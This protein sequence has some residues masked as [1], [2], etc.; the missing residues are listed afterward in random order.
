MNAS[1]HKA[2]MMAQIE[3]GTP[4]VLASLYE[5]SVTPGA[6][7]NS[8]KLKLAEMGLKAMG[9]MQPD[10]ASNFVPVT[11]TFVNGGEMQIQTPA[12]Q[13]ITEVQREAAVDVQ[14]KEVRP[15][16]PASEPVDWL[17]ALDVELNR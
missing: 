1:D 10:K 7:S 13:M 16:A 15:P 14:A 4:L 9:V 8:D 6:M 2:I 12:P 5:L 11:I 3:D 17:A